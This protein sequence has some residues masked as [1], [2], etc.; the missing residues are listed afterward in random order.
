MSGIKG[1]KREQFEDYVKKVGLAE[2]NVIAINP[3]LQEYQDVLGFTPKEDQNEF[4]YTGVSR[5]GNP[6][7]RIDVW[8]KLDG[9]EEAPMKAVFFLED[10][11]R[12][13]KDET[14]T[15][16]INNI[17]VCS[18]AEDEDS[19]PSWFAKRNYREAKN[20]EEDLY[21]FLRTW[22]A[23]DYRDEET[24]LQLDFRK[25]I[26]GNLDVLKEQIGGELATTIVVLCTVVT[27]SKENDEGEEITVEYQGIYN[28]QFLPQYAMKHFRVKNYN[29][30][31]LIA[32]IQGK[33][34]KDCKIHEKF[35]QN[36]TGEYGCKDFYK[37]SEV[38]DYNPE[39]NLASSD[40]SMLEAE[41]DSSSS[42]Y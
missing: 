2:V 32:T 22:L 27:K 40:K 17:G 38:E 5:D 7:V 11:V 8:L 13:N 9:R 4:E 41:E 35:V 24:E 10:K 15:Q 6:F 3:S 29:D 31:M 37:L 28:K 18:W 12:T 26:T 42:E 30:P 20:G 1:K 39:D 21:T 36:V 33:E 25:L 19:L 16:Y 14:K 23:L 34:L